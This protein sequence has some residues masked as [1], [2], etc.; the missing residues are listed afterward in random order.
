MG[1]ISVSEESR[2]VLL[3]FA[4]KQGDL[5]LSAAEQ[6]GQAE[7]KVGEVIRLVA[8]THEFQRA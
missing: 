2:S 6:D 3:E 4:S 7:R 8:A 1:A 5:E